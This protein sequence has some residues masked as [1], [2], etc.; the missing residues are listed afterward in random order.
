MLGVRFLQSGTQITLE[1]GQG[2]KTPVLNL[3]LKL[4][5]SVAS[6]LEVL[7][8]SCEGLELPRTA[9][10]QGVADDRSDPGQQRSEAVTEK[11]N[12]SAPST[13]P[14]A[15]PV[16]LPLPK[17]PAVVAQDLPS[18][19]AQ[20]GLVQPPSIQTDD[21]KGEEDETGV[22]WEPFG[23]PPPGMPT[24]DA[25]L[26]STL[27]SP[28][29]SIPPAPTTEP[30]LPESNGPISGHK[31]KNKMLESL[32]EFS[33]SAATSASTFTLAALE[34]DLKE[35]KERTLYAHDTH[36]AQLQRQEG[37]LQSSMVSLGNRIY[38][39][40]NNM[41]FQT[42]S[43]SRNVMEQDKRLDAMCEGIASLENGICNELRD[44]RDVRDVA[45]DLREGP[46]TEADPET[47]ETSAG[48]ATSST[49]DARGDSRPHGP[50]GAY[51]ATGAR[52]S[53]K[54]GRHVA[55]TKPVGYGDH[56]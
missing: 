10:A 29:A 31:K 6:L 22:G 26:F 30:H 9:D 55:W 36:R 2:E 42:A 40:A 35:L 21:A 48:N 12:T 5:L 18:A 46:M 47:V 1:Q 17:A 25:S 20:L 53:G 44:L 39:L 16:V 8:K 49:R 33:E 54:S 51:G 56:W 13:S 3:D 24:Q 11:D 28:H 7:L 23:E 32:D 43:I 34:K 19:A 52:R 4:Q 38:N 50:H 15:S 45:R 27:L 41:K 14:A 37:H